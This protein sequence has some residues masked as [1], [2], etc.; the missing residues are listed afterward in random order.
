MDAKEEDAVMGYP[1]KTYSKRK[2]RELLNHYGSG[3]AIARA[4]GLAGTTVT[5]AIRGGGCWKKTRAKFD[6]ALA[7]ARRKKREAGVT[8][9]TYTYKGTQRHAD[10]KKLIAAAVERFGSQIALGRELGVADGVVSHWGTGQYPPGPERLEELR[11]LAAGESRLPALARPQSLPE[12]LSAALG[13]AGGCDVAVR[14]QLAEVNRKLDLLLA[15]WEI[16]A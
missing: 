3:E 10:V 5:K 14:E 16:E 11:R 13:G 6:Q 7:T 1:G 2:M 4:T 12:R 8:N 15:A 9:Q